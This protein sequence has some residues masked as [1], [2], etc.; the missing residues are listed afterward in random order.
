MIILVVGSP[1]H[2]AIMDSFC[3]EIIVVMEFLGML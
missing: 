2:L 1:K 3:R